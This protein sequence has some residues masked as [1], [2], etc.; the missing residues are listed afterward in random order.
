MTNTLLSNVITSALWTVALAHVISDRLIRPF[1]GALLVE[2]LPL[3][4]DEEPLVL[5]AV[6]PTVS[7]TPEP[8]PQP[9]ITAV[10]TPRKRKPSRTRKSAAAIAS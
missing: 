2:L 3:A 7:I 4:S 6:A 1:L 9:V 8:A 5:T 10:A